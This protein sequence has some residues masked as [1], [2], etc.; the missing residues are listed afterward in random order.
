MVHKIYWSEDTIRR[1][2]NK[3]TWSTN[4]DHIFNQSIWYML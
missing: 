2:E 3:H 4:W 1:N